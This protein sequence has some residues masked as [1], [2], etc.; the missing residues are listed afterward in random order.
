[1][2]NPQRHPIRRLFS[3]FADSGKKFCPA[4]ADRKQNRIFN[5]LYL[6][7][8]FVLVILAGL[9]VY[10]YYAILIPAGEPYLTYMWPYVS[11]LALLFVTVPGGWVIKNYT[12]QRILIANFSFVSALIMTGCYSIFLGPESYFNFFMFALLPLP[13]FFFERKDKANL[14]LQLFLAIFN[15]VGFTSVTYAYPPLFPLPDPV[16]DLSRIV[17]LISILFTISV[18][19]FYFWNENHCTSI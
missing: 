8:T 17:V 18:C 15:I 4:E 2:T 10:T 6:Y 16:N 5:I 7:F 13:F 11:L 3:R 1:M 14:R 19:S 12:G 9:E